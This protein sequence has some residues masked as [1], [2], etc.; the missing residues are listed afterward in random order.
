[1]VEGE[2]LQ[3][4]RIGK[5]DVTE[6]DYMELIDRKTASLFSACARLGGLMG[7]ADDACRSQAG[8]VRLEPGNRFPTGGRCSRL[9]RA[10]ECPRASRSATICAK[11][12]VTL[13]LIYA[14]AEATAGR[15]RHDRH[16]PERRQLRSCSVQQDPDVHRAS[17]GSSVRANAPNPSR[18]KPARSSPP[19]RIRPTSGP[20]SASPTSSPNATTNAHSD[21]PT[22]HGFPSPAT[23]VSTNT[24]GT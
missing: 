20:C 24:S 19:F 5:L 9:H 23:N 4:E 17:T 16:R 3:L 7:G 8:R 15:A 1:M 14:L 6:A 12:K 18:K 11:G 2:L 13:P 10:R 21:R 22:H